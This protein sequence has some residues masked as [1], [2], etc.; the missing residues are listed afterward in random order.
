[1]RRLIAAAV[2]VVAVACASAGTP[3]GVVSTLTNAMRTEIESPEH[4]KK[5]RSMALTPAY[6]DPAG[7]TKVWI[8]AEQRVKPVIASLRPH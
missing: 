1:M 3:P 6:L 8:D 2:A 4:Q 7:F 5:L